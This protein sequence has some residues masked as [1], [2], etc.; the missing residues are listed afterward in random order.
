MTQ[1]HLKL[2]FDAL[3]RFKIYWNLVQKIL[4]TASCQINLSPRNLRFT[5]KNSLIDLKI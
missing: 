1:I 4:I 3:G 5:M 2:E